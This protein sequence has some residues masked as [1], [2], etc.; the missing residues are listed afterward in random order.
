LKDALARKKRQML[1][2][3]EKE[4]SLNLRVWLDGIIFVLIGAAACYALLPDRESPRIVLNPGK[5]TGNYS[6][7]A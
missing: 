7:S 4:E 1:I 6:P 5:Y 2:A 3:K